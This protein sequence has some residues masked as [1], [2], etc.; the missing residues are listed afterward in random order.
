MNRSRTSQQGVTLIEFTLVLVV[1]GLLLGGILK[2]TELIDN[3]KVKS[4]ADRNQSI[5]FAWYT[6]IDRYGGTP[7]TI[8]DIQNYLPD[9]QVAT[10][11]GYYDSNRVRYRV[12]KFAFQNLAVAGLLRCGH[13]T[14][15]TQSE[16]NSISNSPVNTYGGFY[17]INWGA[18]NGFRKVAHPRTLDNSDYVAD[19]NDHNILYTG[20]G[21][22][23][24]LMAELDRKIDDGT[25]NKGKLRFGGL[26]GEADN[27]AVCTTA[28]NTQ[29][30]EPGDMKWRPVPVAR[31]C[32]G[33]TFL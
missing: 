22:P 21:I 7:G 31:N 3:A 32:G 29:I 17:E 18:D 4:L 8:S 5:Q 15:G 24:N 12:S 20:K 30:N 27:R 33:A 19:Y 26:R 2:T 10:W 14:G 13:C 1:F 9:G 25:P 11:R 16:N 23:S 28:T 6:F